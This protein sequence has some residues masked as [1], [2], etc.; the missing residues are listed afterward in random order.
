MRRTPVASLYAAALNVVWLGAWWLGTP[1]AGTR[2][3]P[4]AALQAAAAYGDLSEAFA[5]SRS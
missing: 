1:R 4:F 5:T 3:A 2:C